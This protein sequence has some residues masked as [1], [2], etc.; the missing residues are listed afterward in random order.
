VIGLRNSHDKSF[1]A[2]IAMGS[3]V[4]CCDNLVRRVM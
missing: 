2:A 4:F 3:S 1:P